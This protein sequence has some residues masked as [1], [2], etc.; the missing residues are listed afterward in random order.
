M[1]DQTPASLIAE[2]LA[3]ETHIDAQKK[4]FTDYLKP[5]GEEVEAKKNQLLAL[6]ND[7]KVQNISVNLEHGRFTAYKFD[8]HH[9]LDR[10]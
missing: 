8:N 2:I 1:T 10:R 5:F 7:M 4:K 9:A 6:L 3:L